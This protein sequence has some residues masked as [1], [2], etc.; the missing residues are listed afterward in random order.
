MSKNGSA[1]MQQCFMLL[2]CAT[3]NKAASAYSFDV[4]AIGAFC[5]TVNKAPCQ[6]PKTLL[7]TLFS[8]HRATCRIPELG[9]QDLDLYRNHLTG[10]QNCLEPQAVLR[11]TAKL[12]MHLLAPFCIASAVASLAC[13]RA[14]PRLSGKT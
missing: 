8:K 1:S 11:E 4:F 2:Q 14:S 5:K 12:T 6:L 10:I 7:V 13:S 9:Q 3:C